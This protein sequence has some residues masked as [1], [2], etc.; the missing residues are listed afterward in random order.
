MKQEFK[1]LL[2]GLL[3]IGLFDFFGS[4]AS[5]H[6]DFNYTILA[7]VSLLI[8]GATGFFGA[9]ANGLK[10]GVLFAAI[11]GLFDSTI[12]WEISILL[13]ANTGN[14]KNN[15]TIAV[16]ITTAIIVTASAALLGLIGSALARIKKGKV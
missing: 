16:W 8:Y 13:R 2:V 14:F 6:F 15:P 7:S 5:R 11:V 1:V 12:G 3:S 9:R 4:I 10:T